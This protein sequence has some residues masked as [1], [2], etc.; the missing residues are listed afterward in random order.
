MSL[1]AHVYNSYRLCGLRFS[2][3]E[4]DELQIS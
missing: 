1:G 4:S 3:A 2:Q